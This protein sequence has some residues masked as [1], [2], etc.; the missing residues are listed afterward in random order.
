MIVMGDDHRH[1]YDDHDNDDD[2]IGMKF[3]HA[4]SNNLTSCLWMIVFFL[5]LYKVQNR[6]SVLR[7]QCKRFF[8]PAHFLLF[9]YLIYDG[10]DVQPSPT[11]YSPMPCHRVN[12]TC[13]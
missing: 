1:H 7:Q 2:K 10:F 8:C 3:Y 9:N 12:K 11:I 13:K 6:F 4:R 5:A